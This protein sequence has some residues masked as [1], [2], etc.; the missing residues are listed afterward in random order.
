MF[1]VYILLGLCVGGWKYD[2]FTKTRNRMDNDPTC[3]L[4]S[5]DWKRKHGLL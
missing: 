5:D 3:T 4:K 2:N 1:L